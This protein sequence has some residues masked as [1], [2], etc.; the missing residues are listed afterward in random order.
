MKYFS[1]ESY[2]GGKQSSDMAFFTFKTG[3]FAIQCTKMLND[4]FED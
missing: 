2:A 1:R 3:H 4:K